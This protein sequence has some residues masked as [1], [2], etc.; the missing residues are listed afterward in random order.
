MLFHPSPWLILNQLSYPN[1]TIAG[2]KLARFRVQINWRDR[3][4]WR[5]RKP[6]IGVNIKVRMSLKCSFYTLIWANF[7]LHGE[8][9]ECNT[10]TCLNNLKNQDGCGKN[11]LFPLIYVHSGSSASEDTDF[12]LGSETQSLHTL[13][14][15]ILSTQL[16]F[17]WPCG[18]FYYP[19]QFYYLFCWLFY[20]KRKEKEVVRPH[21][22]PTIHFFPKG[23]PGFHFTEF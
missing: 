19:H 18:L 2:C 7:E 16:S 9:K 5:E 6:V 13:Q 3:V 21:Q 4:Q 23:H 22:S 12:G 8:S 10:Q 17:E 11:N 14:L 1:G 20:K 15:L